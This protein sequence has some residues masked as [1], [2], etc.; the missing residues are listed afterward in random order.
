MIVCETNNLSAA[1][2]PRRA[3]ASKTV[4]EQTERKN[5]FFTTK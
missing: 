4:I 3:V 1:D 5:W 2:P